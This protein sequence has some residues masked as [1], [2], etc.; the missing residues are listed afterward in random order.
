[1]RTKAPLFKCF[2]SCTSSKYILGRVFSFL[3]PSPGANHAVTNSPEAPWDW[4][5]RGPALVTGFTFPSS[6]GLLRGRPASPGGRGG[7]QGLGWL[8]PVSARGGGPHGLT[9]AAS[10]WNAGTTWADS[11]NDS[12]FP[13]RMSEECFLVSK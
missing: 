5:G 1:M 3:H 12:L 7:A 6:P 8:S 4:H 11:M 9:L 2:P 10:V 13:L